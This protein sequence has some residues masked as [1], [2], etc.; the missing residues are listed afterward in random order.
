MKIELKRAFASEDGD[1][2]QVVFETRD[3]EDE[4]YV[5]LQRQFEDPDGGVCY[6]ETHD[7]EYIG[8]A[9]VASASLSRRG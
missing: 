8:H 4:P 9:K 6:L 2:C 7:E 1:Y 3:A 5:L